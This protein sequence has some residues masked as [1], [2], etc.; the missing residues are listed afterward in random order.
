MAFSSNTVPT[1]APQYEQLA[2]PTEMGMP[3]SKQTLL[4][5]DIRPQI[6]GGGAKRIVQ[7]SC[8][9]T[10]FLV[11]ALLRELD[12]EKRMQSKPELNEHLRFASADPLAPSFQLC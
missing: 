12:G 5:D 2:I 9:I 4:T 3:H 6:S 10:R 11:Q 1:F 7:A 8:N